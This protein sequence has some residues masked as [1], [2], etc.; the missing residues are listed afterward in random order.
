V[1][2]SNVLELGRLRGLQ[3]MALHPRVV[4]R[5]AFAAVSLESL[6]PAAGAFLRLLETQSNL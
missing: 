5:V 1:L 2:P 3:T 4:R 6:T